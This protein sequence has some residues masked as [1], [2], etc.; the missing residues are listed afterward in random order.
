MNKNKTLKQAVKTNSIIMVVIAIILLIVGAVCSV[1]AMKAIDNIGEGEPYTLKE[2]KLA[3]CKG[4]QES[5]SGLCEMIFENS[6]SIADNKSEFEDISCGGYHS[7]CLIKHKKNINW[8]FD[9]FDKK[10][11]KTIDDIDF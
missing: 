6:V 4:D 8:I 3:E 11:S 7:L 2:E 1:Q 9:D 5:N 10:I